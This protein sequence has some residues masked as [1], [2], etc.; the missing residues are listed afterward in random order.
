[1]NEFLQRHETAVRHALAVVAGLLLAAAFPK[2][3]IAGLA[4][5]AP[6]LLLFSAAGVPGKMAFRLGWLGGMAFHLAA[7]H[8]LLFIPV[9]GFP[10][11]GWLA[12]SAYCAV[13]PGLWVWLCWRLAPVPAVCN[14]RPDATEA[15]EAAI[16]NRRHGPLEPG[17]PRPD[18][19]L[20]TWASALHWEWR[21]DCSCEGAGGERRVIIG[22]RLSPWPSPARG[23]STR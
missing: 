21:R 4:W 12:L 16:A 3:G 9:T 2:L 17:R 23:T 10:I 18:A 1:M 22:R 20:R 8:W 13:Y 15:D 19:E 14:R 5:I 7:L 6:G 11:L